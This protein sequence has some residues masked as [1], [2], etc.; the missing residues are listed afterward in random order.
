MTRA[1][2]AQ[3]LW[4]IL[5]LAATNRQILTYSIVEKLTGLHRAGIGDCLRPIQQ[6]CTEQ[7]LPALTSL[8]VSEETGL[9]GVGFI[10]AQDVPAA[11][12]RVFA[13]HWLDV[14][15]PTEA[16]FEDAYSR[17]PDAR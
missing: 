5:V 8:V 13:H 2:R 4:G 10:A 6:Y 11:Q 9:P 14:R 7:H 1:E 15:A 3:Q 16:Q 17:A 12:V